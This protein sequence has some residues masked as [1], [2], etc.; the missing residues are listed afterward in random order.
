MTCG[1]SSGLRRTS[2]SSVARQL[3]VLLTREDTCVLFLA[4]EYQWGFS[5]SKRRPLGLFLLCLL[6]AGEE[7]AIYFEAGKIIG[8]SSDR[9][10]PLDLPRASNGHWIFS[11]QRRSVDLPRVR[12]DLWVFHRGFFK[13]QRPLCFLRAKEEVWVFFSGHRRTLGLL[14]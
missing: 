13:P 11:S 6:R 4:R 9:R 5:F 10:R 12:E 3:G 1:S 2:T 7:Y 8:S 14:L